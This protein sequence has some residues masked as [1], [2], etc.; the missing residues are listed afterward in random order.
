M[1]EIRVNGRIGRKR[2]ELFAP[3]TR[4]NSVTIEFSVKSIGDIKFPHP[5]F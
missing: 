4:S 2:D 1:T 5:F 3:E